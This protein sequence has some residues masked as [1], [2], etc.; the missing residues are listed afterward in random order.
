MIIVLANAAKDNW[1]RKLKSNR[2]V[3]GPSAM[4]AENQKSKENNTINGQNQ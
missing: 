3:Y 4:Q 1:V 2:Q